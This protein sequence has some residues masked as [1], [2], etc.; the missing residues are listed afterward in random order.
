MKELPPPVPGQSWLPSPTSTVWFYQFKSDGH[1]WADE[2]VEP[3]EE[4]RWDWNDRN[5]VRID[6]PTDD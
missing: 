2:I 3:I 5:P 4:M 1:I 6:W